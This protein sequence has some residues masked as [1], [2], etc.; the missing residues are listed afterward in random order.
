LEVLRAR[1]RIES[2]ER[3]LCAA[4]R[5]KHMAFRI[6]YINGNGRETGFTVISDLPELRIR[7]QAVS[8]ENGKGNREN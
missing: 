7:Y 5:T 6:H 4:D 2:L 8:E 3:V 1:R